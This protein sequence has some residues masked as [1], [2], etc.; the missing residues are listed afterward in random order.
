MTTIE[1]E[2]EPEQPTEE[3]VEPAPDA[4]SSG[5]PPVEPPELDAGSPYPHSE[6]LWSRAILPLA[7][8]ILACITI[9]VWVIN[10]SRAFLAGSKT[11]AVVVVMVVTISIMAGAA[12][13]SASTRMRST[14]RLL[15]AS[16]MLLL[17]MSAGLVSLGPSEEEEGGETA[18]YVP[19]K[20]PT[21]D[22][23]DVVALASI[24]F[25]SDE[26]TIPTGGIINVKFSGAPAHTLLIEDA[27]FVGFVLT[28][29]PKTAEK[30]KL[31]P[32]EYTIYCNV[33]GHRAAGM[34]A[35]VT[36]G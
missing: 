21:V 17:I 30:A 35:T 33:A 24:E 20:G 12:F 6:A 23:L 15:I 9:A 28:S 4:P 1:T 5:G 25:D 13:M 2:A 8:P 27:K 29:S 19:P 18:A 16:A 7:L 3:P 31:D 34:E 14:S 32:G 10:L 36:V 11:G 22:Q 26:Y